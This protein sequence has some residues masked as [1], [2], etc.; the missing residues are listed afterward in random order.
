MARTILGADPGADWAGSDARSWVRRLIREA[1][2]L[3]GGGY[4]GLL[5][6]PKRRQGR[7]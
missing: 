3:V 5:R 1:Q 4:R 2:A 7:A 6:P